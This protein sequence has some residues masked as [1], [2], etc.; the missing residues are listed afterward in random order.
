MPLDPHVE[1]FL[2]RLAAFPAM[3]AEPLSVAARREGLK[4]LLEIAGPPAPVAHI[5]RGSFPGPGGERALRIY[6]PEE[7]P[8]GALP[9]LIFFHGGGL[10]AG[11]LDSYS[12]LCRALTRSSGC[13]LIAVDY[14]LAPEHPFPAALEDAFAATVWI[15]AHAAQL[16]LDPDRLVVAGDSAGGTLAAAVCQ[17]L[18]AQGGLKPALQLLLCPILDYDAQTPSRL[19]FARGF[20]LEEAMLEHDRGHQLTAGIDAADPRVSPLRAS[21]LAG[22]APTCI[23]GAEF[24]PVRDEAADYARRLERAGVASTWCCHSGMIH[25]FYALGGVIPYAGE[26]LRRIGEDIRAHV[27]H[28]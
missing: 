11:E 8:P 7:S 22:V 24:D 4:Q 28:R 19:E 12:A 26:A 21:S 14:R 2:S 25:L 10:V 23:H 1:R 6:T 9:G 5:E 18:A 27:K 3:H 20:L 13:R 15:G 16:G 17:R